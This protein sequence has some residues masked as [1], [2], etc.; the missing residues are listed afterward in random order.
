MIQSCNPQI[1]A[2]SEEGDTFV[3]KQP[4][5]FEKT[6]IPQFFKHSKFSSFVRQ[7]NFYGF[8]KIKYSDTIK[9][10]TKLEAETANF[11]RFKHEKFLRGKPE[12]L[13]EI[14]RH[15][16]QSTSEK[17]KTDEKKQPEKEVTS[18]K[19][20]VD[21]LKDKIAN[22]TKNIDD[23]TVLVQNISVN[24]TRTQMTMSTPDATT[25]D[26]F[27][28]GNKRKKL[29]QPELVLSTNMVVDEVTSVSPL[30]TENPGEM[31]FTPGTIFPSLSLAERQESTCTNISHDTFM[32]QMLGTLEDD[33]DILPD[34]IL[35]DDISDTVLELP[36]I[37]GLSPAPEFQSPLNAPDPELMKKLSNALCVLPH[38][39]QDMLVNRLI[40][41]VTSSDAL[42]SH[43]DAASK[44]CA[45]VESRVEKPLET[46]VNHSPEIDLP[47]A[48]AA[49]GAILT[50]C[51]AA[52]MK[53]EK[54]VHRSLPVIPIHA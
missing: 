35:S 46:I 15:N 1:A 50:Q 16:S 53:K 19:S 42:K 13:S 22:M 47:M 43:I 24:D 41:T 2:W 23:L 52:S 11:W 28:I 9:I 6:I 12:L 7:L 48:V 10:D 31:S 17:S 4:D 14:R 25:D 37:E 21:I 30:S 49:L 32:E 26:F 5:V 44:S 45:E 27:A 18:L 51:S 8:R 3:V 33:L 29:V 54:M 40:A 20:E 36:Q 39:I 34:T 38:K